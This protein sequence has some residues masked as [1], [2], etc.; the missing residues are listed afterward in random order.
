MIGDLKWDDWN[1][2][3]IARHHVE[4]WEVEEMVQNAPLLIRMG[5]PLGRV[6]LI[7]QSASGRYLAA[8]ADPEDGDQ[9]YVVSRKRRDRCRTEALR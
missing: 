6:H 5:R 8:F 1:V 3:H 4:Y 9:Y 7:G 2:E